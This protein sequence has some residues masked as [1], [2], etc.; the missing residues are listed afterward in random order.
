M[1]DT[2]TFTTSTILDKVGYVTK[3][4]AA[5]VVK[6]GCNTG[7]N[8]CAPTNRYTYQITVVGKDQLQLSDSVFGA[9]GV[10]YKGLKLALLKLVDHIFD[11]FDQLKDE[12]HPL[13]C[14]KFA[15]ELNEEVQ[16]AVDAIVKEGILV[17]GVAVETCEGACIVIN[18]TVDPDLNT[19]SEDPVTF[20]FTGTGAGINNFTLI[21]DGIG[22]ESTTFSARRQPHEH[23]QNAFRRTTS[24]YIHLP[25][26]L[27]G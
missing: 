4:K 10:C 6:P 14:K 7:S 18:K 9:G 1:L 20:G 22:G 19:G 26:H 15:E 3:S 12:E 16:E 2:G 25:H 11:K 17:G 24:M 13:G 8:R 27:F 5:S 23:H 21:T